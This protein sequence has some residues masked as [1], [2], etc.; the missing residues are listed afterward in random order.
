ME[1][2][3]TD[4]AT[5]LPNTVR[6]AV[7]YYYEHIEKRDIGV[8]RLY[9]LMLENS[10]VYLVRTTTDGDDGWIE[11][12]GA[13]GEPFGTGRTYIEQVAWGETAE[14]RAQTGTGEFPNHLDMQ[15]T[16]WK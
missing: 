1:N 5:A 6:E 2:V 11:L 9:Q 7:D 8:V 10:L 13:T 12:F 4:S 14:L 16:L 15:A 3:L